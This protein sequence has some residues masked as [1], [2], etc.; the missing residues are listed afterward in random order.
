[1]ER[2]LQA[3]EQVTAT[4]IGSPLDPKTLVGPLHTPAAVRQYQE[5]LEAVKKEGG[6]VLFGGNVLSDQMGGGNF[7]MPTV[8]RVQPDLPCVQQEVFVPILHTMTFKVNIY[9]YI[10][11]YMYIYIYLYIMIY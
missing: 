2:L 10:Y 5:A 3:Y 8:T 6:Q 4:R 11:I 7:V 9:V 1:M